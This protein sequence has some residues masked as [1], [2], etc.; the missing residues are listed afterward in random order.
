MQPFGGE[1]LSGTGPK[2]GG[3]H[4]L[5]QLSRKSDS[6]V[7]SNRNSGSS[8]IGKQAAVSSETMIAI[9]LASKASAVWAKSMP[10]AERPK[11][12]EVEFRPLMNDG[13]DKFWSRLNCETNIILPGP[14]GESNILRLHPR[15][16]IVCAGDKSA[17]LKQAAMALYAGNSAIA[18]PASGADEIKA[19]SKALSEKTKVANL[20]Q[21]LDPITLSALAGAPINGLAADGPRRAFIGP[22][23]R[24]REGAI[25]PVLSQ[26][27]DPE[28]FFHERTVTINTTAAGGNATL[29][30][31][32]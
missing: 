4:Y 3:P 17:V 24:K 23:F 2:A 7:P 11:V 27:S 12:L 13:D 10:A 8:V 25:L 26:N 19:L 31:L 28:R 22:I 1:G 15:G 29:L 9:E 18:L 30:T 14:T 6:S 5:L 32:S 20:L 16:V 21:V